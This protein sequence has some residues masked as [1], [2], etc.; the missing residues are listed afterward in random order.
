VREGMV[1]VLTRACAGALVVVAI[2]G[3]GEEARQGEGGRLAGLRGVAAGWRGDGVAAAAAA[4]A[5]KA[6]VEGAGA[7]S[8]EGASRW[9]EGLLARCAC[10]GV[11]PAALS[12][13]KPR[14]AQGLSVCVQM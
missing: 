11:R 13:R 6:V 10:G 12:I 9:A 8:C 5:V 3:G 14:R 2:A 1:L 4:A 7:G